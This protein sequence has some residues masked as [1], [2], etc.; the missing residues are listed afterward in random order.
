MLV[1]VQYLQQFLMVVVFIIYF[2]P[3]SFGLN[4]SR[5]S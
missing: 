1:Y 3:L 4:Y 2:I 5:S